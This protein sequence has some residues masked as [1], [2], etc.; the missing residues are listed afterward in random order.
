MSLAWYEDK[1]HTAPCCGARGV[2]P[3]A[4]NGHREQCG[5]WLPRGAWVWCKALGCVHSASSIPP[6]LQNIELK[7]EVESL[8]RELQEKQQ[9]LDKTW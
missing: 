1:K 2:P 7:V 4:F 6:A 3:T 9:A 5:V 8:K